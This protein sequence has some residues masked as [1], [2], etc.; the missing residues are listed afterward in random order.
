MTANAGRQGGTSCLTRGCQV[1][2]GHHQTSNFLEASKFQKLP[3]Q[4]VSSPSIYGTT[5][6]ALSTRAN[7]LPTEKSIRPRQLAPISSCGL[8]ARGSDWFH[9]NQNRHNNIAI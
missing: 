3:E 5:F 4:P 8:A 6:R 7:R 9:P 2:G 1:Q